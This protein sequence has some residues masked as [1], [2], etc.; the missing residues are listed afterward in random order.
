[1]RTFLTSLGITS[2][3]AKLTMAAMKYS[4]II[5]IGI[6]FESKINILLEAECEIN[7]VGVLQTGSEIGLHNLSSSKTPAPLP[8]LP[9]A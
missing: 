9:Q 2:W 4:S 1:M 3:H 5:E 6:F 8:P 7:K